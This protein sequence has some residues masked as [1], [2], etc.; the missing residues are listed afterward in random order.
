VPPKKRDPERLTGPVAEPLQSP[1]QAAHFARGIDLFHQ[2]HYWHAH[3][4][5]ECAW[6]RMGNGPEDDAE[7]VLRGLIQL[8]AALHAHNQGR[9]TAARANLDKAIEKLARYPGGFW[10]VDIPALA[11]RMAT[12]A[13]GDLAGMALP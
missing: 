9:E 6:K 7:F 5:W 1:E 4:A 10:G 3:E 8:C 13:P 2:Q 12:S 11:Q